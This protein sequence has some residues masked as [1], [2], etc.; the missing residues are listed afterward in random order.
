MGS[1]LLCSSSSNFP[2]SPESTFET[3]NI[4]LVFLGGEIS[5]TTIPKPYGWRAKPKTIPEQGCQMVYFHTQKP[6][7]VIFLET[8]CNRLVYL[9]A[10]C[11]ILWHLTYIAY[12]GS[13]MIYFPML[14]NIVKKTLAALYGKLSTFR[15]SPKN[16]IR[17]FSKISNSVIPSSRGQRCDHRFRRY[18]PIFSETGVE[19]N[20]SCM[21]SFNSSKKSTKIA[22]IIIIA[23]L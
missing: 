16:T 3:W 9:M 2:Y 19:I 10:N 5:A 15:L 14:K 6:I 23:K 18:W 20:F 12:F 17:C 21:K 13:F 7:F 22:T 4:S 11:F 1:T 8:F